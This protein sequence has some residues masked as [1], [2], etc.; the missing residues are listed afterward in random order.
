VVDSEPIHLVCFSNVLA[1]LDVAM[2]REDYYGKY[3]GF[4]DH[5]CFA[6]VLQD[7]GRDTDEKLIT[8]LIAQK[9]TLVRQ[10]ISSDIQALPGAFEL[11]SAA[12][13]AGVA[14]AICSGALR[15]EI[16]LALEKI[17]AAD[18]F[19][20]VV[21]AEDVSRGKPEPEGYVLT[22][23]RLTEVLGRQVQGRQCVVIEDSPA[24]IDAAHGAGLCVLGVTTSYPPAAMS[25]A[26]RV[27]ALLSD[28]RLADLAAMVDRR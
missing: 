15:P 1:G 20:V 25:G 7:N 24:G 8:R 5:D 6:A 28:V 12:A 14:L 19:L 27:V 26:D 9:T 11:I 4:D 13:Q 22:V 10:A 21:S 17:G 18:K 2:T 23:R 3:L 16:D